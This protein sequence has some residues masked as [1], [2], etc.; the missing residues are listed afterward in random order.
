VKMRALM[1]MLAMMLV[2]DVAPN[3]E[4]DAL[5]DEAERH[6]QDPSREALRRLFDKYGG[7]DSG[8]IT[9]EG[10]EHLLES[11]GLGHVVIVDHNVH[12]HQS[13]DG[14][15]RSLHDNHVHTDVPQQSDGHERHA[16]LDTDHPVTTSHD[17]QGRHKRTAGA[18][19]AQ[20]SAVDVANISQVRINVNDANNN[21]NQTRRASV[22]KLSRRSV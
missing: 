9:F 21:N 1:L 10:F 13:E 6:E 4:L 12:D 5:F 18:S 17:H 3:N 8:R 19:T 20:Q 15:F 14:H 16:E 7:R 2:V 11:L 22:A